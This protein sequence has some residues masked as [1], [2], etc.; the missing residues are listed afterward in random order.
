MTKKTFDENKEYLETLIGK[1]IEAHNDDLLSILAQLLK[2]YNYGNRL[3]KKGALTRFII[4]NSNL[5]YSTG[6]KFI[7]FDSKIR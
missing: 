6:E 3:S 4:D 1:L 2:E 7:E 5:D